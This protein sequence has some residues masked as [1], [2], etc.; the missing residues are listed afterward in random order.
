MS[1]DCAELG[2]EAWHTDRSGLSS[3]GAVFIHLGVLHRNLK[4]QSDPINSKVLDILEQYTATS[5][6]CT[7]RN[8]LNMSQ[9]TFQPQST[10]S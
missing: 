2:P 4:M 8:L 1:C 6:I 7:E 5:L 9:I 10:I 3:E